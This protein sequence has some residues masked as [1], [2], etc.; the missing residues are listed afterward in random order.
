MEDRLFGGRV[1]LYKF[2]VYFWTLSVADTF[3]VEWYKYE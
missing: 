2:T 3:K 1:H